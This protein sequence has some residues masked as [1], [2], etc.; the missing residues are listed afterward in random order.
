MMEARGG[1]IVE[2]SVVERN[3]GGEQWRKA[4]AGEIRC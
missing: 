2:K 4:Q 3:Y 1:A